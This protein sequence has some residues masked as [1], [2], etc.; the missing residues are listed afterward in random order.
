MQD[1]AEEL[2]PRRLGAKIA[3]RLKATAPDLVPLTHDEATQQVLTDW[4]L[5][6]YITHRC[7]VDIDPDA[8]RDPKLRDHW[9]AIALRRDEVPGDY[10]AFGQHA[11]WITHDEKRIGTIVHPR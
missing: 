9:R 11:F 4:D 7:G 3:A 1:Y 8:F 2:D 5:A 10:V 6:S